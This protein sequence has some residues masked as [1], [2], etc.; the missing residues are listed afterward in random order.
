MLPFGGYKGSA[1]AMMVE[2]LAAGLIGESSSYEAARYDM[3]LK[4]FQHRGR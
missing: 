3:R 2:L 1:I 4:R